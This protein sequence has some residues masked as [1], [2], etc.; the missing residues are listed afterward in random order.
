M[1]CKECGNEFE[2]TEKE[3][4]FF[5]DKGLELPKRCKECRLRRRAERENGQEEKEKES[6]Y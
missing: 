2:L 1:K 3:K 5:I 6:R 4:K